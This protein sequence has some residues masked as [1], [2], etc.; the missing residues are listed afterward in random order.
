MPERKQAGVRNQ[1]PSPQSN[2]ESSTAHS[3]PYHLMYRPRKLEDVQGQREIVDAI[4]AEIKRK[5]RQHTFFLF[6]PGGTGKTTLARIMAAEFDCTDVIEI[7]AASNSGIDEMRAVM[8]HMQYGGFGG[9]GNRAYVIDECHRLSSNAWDSL[10]KSTEEPP[11]H[12]FF[13]FCSTDPRKIPAAMLTRGPNYTLQPIRFDDL[14]DRLEAVCEA[15][16]LDTP[17]WALEVAARACGGSMRLALVMLALVQDAKTEE[18]ALRLVAGQ[19]EIPEVVDLCKLI[20]KGVQWPEAM[21]LL[22][23]IDE[24]GALQPETIRIVVTS[25]MAK[26]MMNA[27]GKQVTYLLDV[28]HAFSKPCNPTDKMAPIMLALADIAVFER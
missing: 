5:A 23:Q 7:D 4:R 21:K 20:L 8:A 13:F 19:A 15:E 9:S 2:G 16:K 22:K 18:D 1:E 25:Y 26:V 11:A 17:V 10:L 6:G 12:V 3:E 14:M 27:K 28:L 24:Q